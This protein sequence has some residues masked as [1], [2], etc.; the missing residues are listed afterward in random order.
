MPLETP[1]RFL[2]IVSVGATHRKRSEEHTMPRT[3]C[4]DPSPTQDLSCAALGSSAFVRSSSTGSSDVASTPSHQ[5]L[6][7]SLS[8]Q[9]ELLPDFSYSF[10][11]EVYALTPSRTAWTTPN[12]SS[13]NWDTYSP[14]S[15]AL[16]GFNITLF[17]HPFPPSFRQTVRI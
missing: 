17:L 5:G 13:P 1:A 4:S 3:S 6:F 15:T 14:L 12:N 8:H 16:G 9:L 2:A 10:C 7:H 11:A